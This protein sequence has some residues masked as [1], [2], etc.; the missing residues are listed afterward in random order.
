MQ[1]RNLIRR[2]KWRLRSLKGFVLPWRNVKRLL[3]ARWRR[4]PTISSARN[5]RG[6]SFCEAVEIY[7]AAVVASLPVPFHSE[8]VAVNLQSEP[9]FIFHLKNIEFW[10]LYGGSVL[11]SDSQLLADLSPEVWGVENHPIFSR[12]RLPKARRLA[13]RTA[14]AITPEAPGNYYHWLIDL[15]PRIGLLGST[16][17]GFEFFE[18]LLINGRRAPYEL[19]SLAAAGTPLEKI[20]YVDARDRFQLEEAIIPSM[21]E[22]SRTVAPWKIDVLRAIRDSLPGAHSFTKRMYVS[23]RRAAVRRVLNEQDLEKFLRAAN[24]TLVEL[25][26]KSWK[27]QVA[28]FANAEVILAPH[29]AALANIAFCKPGTLVAEI[30]TRGG[31]KDFYLQL[32]ATARLRYRFIE[33]QPRNRLSDSALRPLENEDLIV[34][35]PAI[36]EFFAAL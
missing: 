30:S 36:E 10:A 12:F 8:E 3:V 29:G 15:L 7:P 5:Y 9:A 23:R 20:W 26:T 1:L 22:F 27:E 19:Q 11:T 17:G 34:D 33:A 32:T 28:A 18:R 21:D 35:L 6:D 2:Q 25:E 13:G 31:Y 4:V 16:K 14:I 24:F